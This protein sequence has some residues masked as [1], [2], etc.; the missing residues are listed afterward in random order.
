VLLDKEDRAKFQTRCALLIF[1]HYATSHPLYTYAFF[2][3]R[4]KRVLYR[5]DAIFLVTTF[6]MRNARVNAGLQ[7]DGEPLAAVRSSLAPAHPPL[8]LEFSF[9]RWQAGD[10][11]PAYEDHT[12]GVPLVDDPDYARLVTPPLLQDW[13]CHYPHHPSFGPQSTV[14]VPVPPRFQPPLPDSVP[15]A[16]D[17]MMSS[18]EEADIAASC[19]FPSDL[20]DVIVPTV[21]LDAGD[22]SS[23]ILEDPVTRSAADFVD[24]PDDPAV[25][26]LMPLDYSVSARDRDQSRGMGNYLRAPHAVSSPDPKRTRL[27][28]TTRDS[29]PVVPSTDLSMPTSLA[30]TVAPI[31][32]TTVVRR[33]TRSR[34]PPSS[35][36][37]PPAP[38]SRVPVCERYYY[39]PV[40]LQA[41]ITTS[42]M[43]PQ[44]SLDGLS[45]H[46]LVFG[47]RPSD[48]VEIP[49]AH[50]SGL[51]TASI[52]R[53]CDRILSDTP[54][55]LPRASWMLDGDD[56]SDAQ[57]NHDWDQA[58]RL[59]FDV[60]P[61]I[62][63][64]P[65]VLDLPVPSPVT[66]ALL[67]DFRKTSSHL[68]LDRFDASSA[69]TPTD[70]P[71]LQPTP[72]SAK[73]VR[74]LLAAKESIFKYGIYLLRNDRD[75]DLSPERA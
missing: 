18:A 40:V 32:S 34:Q 29:S 15:A 28:A 54:S 31:D 17:V 27:N 60:R 35:S 1:I 71:R 61:S 58:T 38:R 25:T 16:P 42:N 26:D 30:P 37:A 21:T 23:Q 69:Y 70:F 73:V 49:S 66:T 52:L 63:D 55:L 74:R 4:S 59:L 67:S 7:A 8:D 22:D 33:S 39:D 72:L 47:T 57:A 64:G 11:L 19:P 50:N 44:D 12:T 65:L 46:E 6:P 3:P 20:P 2:S 14:P 9:D 56:R 45:P 68:S 10:M 43:T 75:A 36:R 62:S 51:D 24:L 5:Q 41:A 13:P 53:Q 48:D